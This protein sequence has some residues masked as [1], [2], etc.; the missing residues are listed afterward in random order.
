MLM[1]APPRCL[2]VLKQL[3]RLAH[4]EA[5]GLHIQHGVDIYGLNKRVKNFQNWNRRLLL[6]QIEING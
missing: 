5:I 4:D 2:K 6:D 3:V 1:S